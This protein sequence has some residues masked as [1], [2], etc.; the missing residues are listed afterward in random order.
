[1]KPGPQPDQPWV[2]GVPVGE[3]VL[4]C[5]WPP[6]CPPRLLR[7]AI[8]AQMGG[9]EHAHVD[10]HN[11]DPAGGHMTRAPRVCYRVPLGRPTVYAWGG[12][13]HE[14]LTQLAR[15]VH[16]LRLPGGGVVD[17]RGVDLRLGV[18]QACTSKAW[19]RY[20]LATPLFPPDVAW[21]R[22]P[23]EDGPERW[24][25]AGQLLERSIT[26]LLGDIGL[27]VRHAVHVHVEALRDA[28][29]EWSRPQRETV[30]SRW[31]FLARW[32]CNARLP[33]GVALG[34]HR[35]EGWGE[36]RPC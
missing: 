29:V 20:E 2:V 23:R 4:D 1:M 26:E 16:A 6:E 33:G 36:V 19:H 9:I 11:H 5:D 13:A 34:K 22:R 18:E 15:D 25:W 35:S 24:A 17:V 8:V 32:A 12:L 7:G 21:G 30:V 14:H 28:R 31:G 10:L 27:E 3:A